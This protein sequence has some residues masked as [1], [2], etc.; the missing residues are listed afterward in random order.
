MICS[1]IA[2]RRS[3]LRSGRAP[4]LLESAES[5]RIQ[6]VLDSLFDQLSMLTL[7]FSLQMGSQILHSLARMNHTGILTP[8][9]ILTIL[10]FGP[11]V[12]LHVM[13]MMRLLNA[14]RNTFEK[15][16]LSTASINRCIEYTFALHMFFGRYFPSGYD[17]CI[18]LYINSVVSLSFGTLYLSFTSSLSWP[19]ALVWLCVAVT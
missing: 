6:T 10:G 1:P 5:S 14:Q 9:L 2:T 19:H 12:R 17:A 7:F 13:F 8:T 4:K 18:M 15:D 3:L 16:V 11:N